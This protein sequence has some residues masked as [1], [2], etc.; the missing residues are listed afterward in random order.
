MGVVNG[1]EATSTLAEGVAQEVW[2]QVLDLAMTQ[3]NRFFQTLTD[4]GFTFGDF[5]ALAVMEPNVA[6]PMGSLAHAWNCDASNATW[7]VDRL[8]ERSL[9]E[10]RTLP[11]DRR[12]KAVALTELGV[13]TKA[14]LFDA[15]HAPPPE[16]LALDPGSL[17]ALRAALA[18][19]PTSLWGSHAHSLATVKTALASPDCGGPPPQ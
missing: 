14:E 17:E 16:F 19:L 4:F 2:A 13:K 11:T 5:R 18:L 10:R 8:E 3:R 9:V 12:V 15:L 1:E 7:V 6:V